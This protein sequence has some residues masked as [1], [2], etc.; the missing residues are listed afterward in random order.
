MTNSYRNL[1]KK[2]QNNTVQRM[3]SSDLVQDKRSAK[4]EAEVKRSRVNP[5]SLSYNVSLQ[6]FS[7]RSADFDDCEFD[8]SEITRAIDTDAY[9]SQSVRKKKEACI[10]NGFFWEGKNPETVQYIK[11]RVRDA[12]MVSDQP[13][14]L[15]VEESIDQI[16]AYN[17]TFTELVRDEDACRGEKHKLNGKSLK[18]IAAI[19]STDP[20]SMKIKR[21]KNGVPQ[22]YR[23]EITGTGNK[24]EWKTSEIVHMFKD[25]RKG[26]A[27]AVPEILPV[28]DD[29][30]ALRRLEQIA[31]ML[32]H[33]NAFPLLHM[34]IGSDEMPCSED[35]IDGQTEITKGQT[36]M[37]DL[38]ANGFAVTSERYEITAIDVDGGVNIAEYLKYFEK[39]VL[40]GLNISDIDIGRGDTANRGT[41]TTMSKNLVN[42]AKSIQKCF[43]LFFN[44]KIVNQW[45]REGGFDIDEENVVFFKFNEI[46]PDTKQAEENHAQAMFEGNTWTRS[47]CRA[48]MGKE[49]FTDEE[50]QDT[51]LHLITLTTLDSETESQIKVAKESPQPTAS[52]GTKSP[53][54]GKGNSKKNSNS[55]KNQSKNRTKAKKS[56]KS[57]S[58]RT[59]TTKST[60]KTKNKNQPSNQFGKKSSA[61]APKK[62]DDLS[63]I[64]NRFADS[65]IEKGTY[66]GV[67]LKR[68]EENV[69]RQVASDYRDHYEFGVE[70]FAEEY[71]QDVSDDFVRLNECTED[72]ISRAGIE[73][74]MDLLKEK[75]PTI[76]DKSKIRSFVEVVKLSLDTRMN[77]VK[78]IGVFKGI[79]DFALSEGYDLVIDPHSVK[80]D[81]IGDRSGQKPVDFDEALYLSEEFDVELS[82]IKEGQAMED[83]E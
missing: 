67:R 46:D 66:L 58:K 18:P 55:G 11:D 77:S 1:F 33:K 48:K 56:T 73:R 69:V 42:A 7:L 37:Q 27:F 26:F 36:A 28:L 9:V 29:V 81:E 17:Q 15:Y 76:K 14:D 43:E 44:F 50:L 6:N 80:S 10:K 82:C 2:S 8:L 53:N 24:K 52:G 22:K 72:T 39:R 49:P 65:Y 78:H 34:K 83:E 75:L 63:A 71:D 68:L 40:S 19:F 64:F 60:R 20:T 12:A 35:S 23:Q 38:P 13:F 47:E 21:N 31:E 32:G 79:Y 45:L 62:N 5:K 3:S 54:P 4:V 25:K 59:G 57:K 16:T 61:L 41:A 30:R 51:F 70:H 74:A